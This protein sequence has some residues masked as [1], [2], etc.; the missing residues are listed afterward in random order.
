MPPTIFASSRAPIWRSSIRRPVAGPEIPEQVAQVDAIVGRVVDEQPAGRDLDAEHLDRKVE[1]ADQLLRL[2]EVLLAL[3][4]ACTSARRSPSCAR[5]S[6]RRSW[7]SRAGTRA[8][9][10]ARRSRAAA[11][12]RYR[13]SRARRGGS[14]D[15]PRRGHELAGGRRT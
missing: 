4:V 9:V 6:T 11:R 5:R 7:R 1:L 10:A 15:R 2:A 8:L 12:D 14:A 13:R 3:L